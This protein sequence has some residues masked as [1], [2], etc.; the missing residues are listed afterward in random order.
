[1]IVGMINILTS[2]FGL[3]F[4]A[5]TLVKNLKKIHR[6]SY[7]GLGVLAFGF[8]A[9]CLVMFTYF[10]KS[11]REDFFITNETDSA[12]IYSNF[13]WMACYIALFY[14]RPKHELLE[15]GTM[16]KDFS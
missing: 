7:M 16:I 6:K 3:L 12:L 14:I 11:P 9:I 4:V 2:F 1:M 5:F 13:I 10:Y 15:E 8:R